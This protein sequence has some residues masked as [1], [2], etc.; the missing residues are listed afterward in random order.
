MSPDSTNVETKS[1]K[2]DDE[3]P[4]V[5]SWEIQE[6]RLTQCHILVFANISIYY[7]HALFNHIS[8]KQSKMNVNKCAK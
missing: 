8:N 7:D 4:E 2:E 3:K 5:V 6:K 1:R